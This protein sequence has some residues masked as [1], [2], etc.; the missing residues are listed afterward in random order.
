MAS[1]YNGKIQLEQ[2]QTLTAYTAM[3]DSGDRQILTAGT[4]WSGKSGYEPSIR[5]NGIY[6][7][8]NVLS[9][10]ASND[11]VT[12]AGFS[13]YVKGSAYTVSATTC[14]F[15]RP[16]TATKA[17][18]YSVTVASDGATVASVKGTISADQ[19]FSEVRAAAGGPP[20]VPPDSIEIGQIRV[21]T[22]TA[23]AVASSEIF[24][25]VG[26]HTE[27]SDYPAYTQS[28]I[29]DGIKAAASAQTNAYIKF[30]SVQPASHTG[31]IGRK[32]YIQ[33]YTPVMADISNSV[34]FS[35]AQESYS[36]SSQQIYKDKTIASTSKSLGA[37]TFTAMLND[38][39]GDSIIAADG[40]LLTV[41]FFPDEN[42]SPY[43]LTQ[44]KI[45]LAVTYPVD[46]QNQAAV[47]VAAEQKTSYFNS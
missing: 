14:T 8:R 22:S 7:G 46:D 13:C 11:K 33:Y 3:T 47:T 23:A 20:L 28:N 41:K 4:L 26:T 45:G 9:T 12:V 2:G 30:D 35:P 27:R 32:V 44:G 10:N 42:K 21:T 19:T 43:S 25:V 31:P 38:G 1:S 40:D 6:S 16:A 17:C 39:I 36:V 37:G 34:D 29:G 18:V 5:P 15:T 24:Q